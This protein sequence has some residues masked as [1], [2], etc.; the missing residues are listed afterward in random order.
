MEPSPDWLNNA[1]PTFVLYTYLVRISIQSLPPFFPSIFLHFSWKFSPEKSSNNLSF[2]SNEMIWITSD[3]LSAPSG[4]WSV[5]N[6]TIAR[7]FRF[8]LFYYPKVLLLF[9]ISTETTSITPTTDITNIS[10]SSSRSK[11][12]RQEIMSDAFFYSYIFF[13]IKSTISTS[14]NFA[15]E[16]ELLYYELLFILGHNI[17][18]TYHYYCYYY[19]YYCIYWEYM[20][21]STYI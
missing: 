15:E 10:S 1:L 2:F 20:Q 7:R 5:K 16:K 8:S 18:R 3:E 21:S 4:L 9:L 19:H 13:D 6:T 14:A 11:N 17:L 12:S